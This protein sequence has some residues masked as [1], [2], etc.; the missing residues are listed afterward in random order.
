M[1]I[2][3]YRKQDMINIINKM[4]SD[5]RKYTLLMDKKKRLGK[6]CTKL[7]LFITAF[8]ILITLV[9]SLLGSNDIIKPKTTIIIM[10]TLFTAGASILLL[11]SRYGKLQNKKYYIYE[12]IKNFCVESIN[13]FKL[14]YSKVAEDDIITLEEYK[15]VINFKNDYDHSK[16]QLKSELGNGYVKIENNGV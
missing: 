7:D 4:D 8:G 13:N 6:I 11:I 10:E 5:I 15:E 14:I 16:I 3:E 12:K 1:E 2:E 9:F